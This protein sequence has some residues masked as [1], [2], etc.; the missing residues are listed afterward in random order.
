MPTHSFQSIP[1]ENRNLSWETQPL[2]Q[3]MQLRGEGATP[4][5]RQGSC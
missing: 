4:K 1:F 2:S 3:S 5:V